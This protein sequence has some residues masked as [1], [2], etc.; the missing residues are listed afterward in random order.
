MFVMY[1][2]NIMIMIRPG[3]LVTVALIDGDQGDNVGGWRTLDGIITEVTSSGLSIG[4][5]NLGGWILDSFL[6]VKHTGTPLLRQ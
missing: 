1:I 6:G 3:M 5:N 4:L 2:V